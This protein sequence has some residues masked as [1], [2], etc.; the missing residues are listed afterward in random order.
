MTTSKISHFVYVSDIGK[1]CGSKIPKRPLRPSGNKVLIKFTSDDSTAGRGFKLQWTAEKLKVAE[2][3][4][5][6]KYSLVKICTYINFYN[7]LFA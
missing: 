4:S 7:L 5:L 2:K 6:V 1:F 3:G